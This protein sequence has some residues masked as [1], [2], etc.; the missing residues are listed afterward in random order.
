M[1]RSI[2]IVL[3]ILLI[4]LQCIIISVSSIL[5]DEDQILLSPSSLQLHL[6][7]PT[8]EEIIIN[9]EKQYF[10]HTSIG[11]IFK[12]PRV[13]KSF[14]NI[15]HDCTL[16]FGTARC[17]YL[18]DDDS[19]DKFSAYKPIKRLNV[20]IFEFQNNNNNNNVVNIT[21]RNGWKVLTSIE[22]NFSFKYYKDKDIV[23]DTDF[24]DHSILLNDDTMVDVETRSLKNIPTPP[25]ILS[26]TQIL[27][28]LSSIVP[29]LKLSFEYPPNGVVVRTPKMIVSM[30]L[31]V[32]D[33]DAF[34][35][36]YNPIQDFLYVCFDLEKKTNLLNVKPISK[37]GKYSR[38]FCSEF[39]EPGIKLS[40]LG[41]GMYALT[42]WLVD[43]STGKY[44]DVIT[45]NASSIF[46]IRCKCGQ[47]ETWFAD[48]PMP[49]YLPYAER[50]KNLPTG[51]TAIPWKHDNSQLWL[52]PYKLLPPTVANAWHREKRKVTLVV[53]V[54]VAATAFE[55]RSALRE[56]WFN[57]K[58][59]RNDCA[60]WFVIGY[61]DE[62]ENKKLSKDVIQKLIEEARTYN[63][64]LL[65]PN[66]AFLEAN[67]PFPWV[68]F[69]VKDS[70]YTLVEKTV[71]F[72]TFASMTYNFQYLF[73]C[74]EDIYLRVD[75]LISVL[76]GQGERFR[77]FA[78]Q[79]WEK[80][81]GRPMRPIRDYESKNYISYQH[82]KMR[83]L[84]PIAIGPHYLMST[85]CVNYIVA[86]KKS[87][88][89]V[90]TLE[91]VSV[92]V[93]LFSIGVHPEDV[94]WFSN[95]KNAPCQEGLV[96]YADL[97]PKF[98]RM[99]HQNLILGDKFCKGMEKLSLA[100][101][102]G[103]FEKIEGV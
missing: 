43:N 10:F 47:K 60:F 76:K 101:G 48:G 17:K 84:P 73:M 98:I 59:D 88:K 20:P 82:W 44:M 70:Y 6:I 45:K 83:D 74:D 85:D 37:S 71:T 91:D 72:M 18:Y 46:E 80:R 100:K 34:N 50:L 23:I 95:A 21:L 55:Y 102:T 96:S 16:C 99:I 4:R 42:A 30:A 12:N 27:S 92:T 97:K 15:C 94:K 90:G 93:W 62:N 53:G 25:T 79:V 77:F 49:P 11:I 56:T 19:D 26:S 86:N 65:G 69:N 75:M 63:D 13:M 33:E 66:P 81:F 36:K 1:M 103:T 54:K 38:D 68:L 2:G 31:N 3:T 51:H 14:D 7:N 61:P 41:D 28:S 29:G 64:M 9:N 87:L 89:G 5:V 35:K 67:L 39:N 24:N 52:P 22:Y 57:R 58:K 32:E 40:G 78:G 8:N